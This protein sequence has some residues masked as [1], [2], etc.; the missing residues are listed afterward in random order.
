VL[1]LGF[2]T[3]VIR[4]TLCLILNMLAHQ[5]SVHLVSP[6]STAR[7]PKLLPKNGIGEVRDHLPL[8]RLYRSGSSATRPLTFNLKRLSQIPW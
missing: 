1:Q 2:R 8:R 7:P 4:L 3:T 5:L 6:I